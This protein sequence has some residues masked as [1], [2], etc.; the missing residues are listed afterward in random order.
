MGCH[1]SSPLSLTHSPETRQVYY[2]TAYW[3]G[4]CQVGTR[5]RVLVVKSAPGWLG[6]T[7][8]HSTLP[9]QPNSGTADLSTAVPW[10]R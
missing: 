8:V 2:N 1:L 3:R 5:V 7:N 6:N 10:F 4:M 9:L